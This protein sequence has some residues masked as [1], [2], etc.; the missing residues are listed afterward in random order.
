[1]LLKQVL[2]STELPL[3]ILDPDSDFVNLDEVVADADPR[4]AKP[5]RDREI[6]ILRRR[7][8]AGGDLLVPFMTLP[9]PAKAA[10]LRL[11]PVSDRDEYNCLMHAEE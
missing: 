11:D 2:S 9:T 3:V 7:S 6:R 1:V 8:T 10:V 5:L 4:D